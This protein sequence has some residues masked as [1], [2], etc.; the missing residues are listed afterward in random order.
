MIPENPGICRFV[1]EHFQVLN[2]IIQHMKY[3]GG[4][5]SG[6]KAMLCAAEIMVVGRCCMYD[7]QILDASQVAKIQ[8]WG[9]CANLSDVQV[10]LGNIRVL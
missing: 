6:H 9:P 5:F 8:I 2:H 10:F 3:C 7:S 4:M 1:W